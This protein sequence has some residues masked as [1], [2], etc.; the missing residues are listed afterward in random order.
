[1]CKKSRFEPV[2]TRHKSACT[3]VLYLPVVCSLASI[4]HLVSIYPKF[5]ASK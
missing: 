2:G 3:I 4:V 5:Q 1:M